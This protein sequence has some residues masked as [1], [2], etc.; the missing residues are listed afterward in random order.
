M[1]LL[2]MDL[3]KLQGEGVASPQTQWLGLEGT[4]PKR[5]ALTYSDPDKGIWKKIKL[6]M[7]SR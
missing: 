6:E 7:G 5:D 2:E 4:G 3:P 1:L